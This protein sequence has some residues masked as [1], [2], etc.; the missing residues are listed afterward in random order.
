[1]LS[2]MLVRMLS[3]VFSAY[4]AP[5]HE[6][7]CRF[8]FDFSQVYW[9]SRLHPEHDRIVKLLDPSDI[10][11]DVFAGVGPF[12]IPA[13]KLGCGIFANDLNP[14][15]AKYLSQNVVNNNVSIHATQENIDLRD[16][17][18]RPC[19]GVLRGWS[20]LHSRCL[21]ATD[22]KSFSAIYW[23]SKEQNIGTKTAEASRQEHI[24]TP[25]SNRSR[26][27]TTASNN[28]SFSHEFARFSH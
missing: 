25:R 13:A 28:H 7:N 16:L 27:L 12:A 23:S 10:L 18:G 15:S 5:K 21:H 20:K 4:S 17:G 22:R 6:S 8:T 26:R 19:T 9:N 1:M 11:A 24:D 3:F 14:N 2:H